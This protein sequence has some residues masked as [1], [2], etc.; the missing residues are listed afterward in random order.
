MASLLELAP[1]FS[2]VVNLAVECQHETA[3]CRDHRLSSRGGKIHDRKATMTKGDVRVA[4]DPGA[5]I[6]G[7]PMS[8]LRRHR[9]DRFEFTWGA[10]HQSNDCTHGLPFRPM[11]LGIRYQLT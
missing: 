6:I 10:A 4:I 7:A 11:A 8:H 9:I 5:V 1:Q 2:E 3:V